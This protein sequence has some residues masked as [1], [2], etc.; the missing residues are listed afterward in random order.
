MQDNRD[1]IE[2]LRVDVAERNNRIEL[3]ED[4]LLKF[5]S[6]L[7]EIAVS[8]ETLQTERERL[9]ESVVSSNIE[10]QELTEK[11]SYAESE[12]VRLEAELSTLATS[13][14][15]SRSLR[16]LEVAA[17]CEKEKSSLQRISEL[18]EGLQKQIQELSA[19][20]EQVMHEKEEISSTGLYYSLSSTDLPS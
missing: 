17:A 2:L 10:V 4:Q 16:E 15:E 7:A 9:H 20:S 6:S 12:N 5:E 1:E 8:C 11:L 18:E 14:E 19:K 13:L 3:L